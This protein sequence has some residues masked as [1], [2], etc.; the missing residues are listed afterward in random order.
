MPIVVDTDKCTGC[1]ECLATCPFDAIE[2]GEGK[3]FINEYCQICMACLNACPEGAIEEIQDTLVT[4]HPLRILREYGSL[5]SR[6]MEKLHPYPMN[7]SAQAENSL[8][9]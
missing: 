7:F 1:K 2:I 6:E 9:S 5:Q 8:M 4:R 3:A